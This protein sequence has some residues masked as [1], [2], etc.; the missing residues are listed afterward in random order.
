MDP[1][2]NKQGKSGTIDVKA[3]LAE[4]EEFLRA[5]LPM[6]PEEVPKAKITEALG[7]EKG[8]RAPGR[9]QDNQLLRPNAARAGAGELKW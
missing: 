2:I 7:T 5:V 1:V 4:D 9:G 3:L 8:E 6:A